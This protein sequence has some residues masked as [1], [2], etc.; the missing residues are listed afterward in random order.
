M[1]KTR[2]TTTPQTI[3]G[4]SQGVN[5]S[6][7]ND[8]QITVPRYI[9][10]QLLQQSMSPQGTVSSSDDVKER[11]VRLETKVETIEGNIKEIKDDRK[12][13][14]T[15][16]LTIFGIVASLAISIYNFYSAE[17]KNT[18]VPTYQQSAAPAPEIKK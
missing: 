13:T 3:E 18:S 8:T 1:D 15:S 5:S 11:I 12:F 6:L 4:T 2:Q 14:L 17:K 7:Y 16:W 10:D 9:F